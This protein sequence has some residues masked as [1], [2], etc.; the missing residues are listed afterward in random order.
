MRLRL[1]PPRWWLVGRVSCGHAVGHG[2]AGDRERRPRRAGGAGSGVSGS[3]LSQR[4]GAQPAGRRAGGRL[5]DRAPGLSDPVSGDLRQDRY[6]VPAGGDP[7]RRAGPHPGGAVHQGRPQDRS[8]ASLSGGPGQDGPVRGGRDRYRPGVRECV[9]R[10][11]AGGVDR[12]SVV[13]LPQGRPA[14]DLLLLLPLGR[15]LRSGV[16]QDLCLLPLP[17]QDLDQRARVGQAPGRP[18]RDRVHRAVQRVRR[19]R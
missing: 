14:G 7:V 17:G 9:H 2:Q 13:R 3:D 6:R 15:R 1:G 11:R 18:G 5:L 19:H 10:D 12:G 16:H 8:D 4:L